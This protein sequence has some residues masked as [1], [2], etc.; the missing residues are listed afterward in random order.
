MSYYSRCSLSLCSNCFRYLESS[1]VYGDSACVN[2]RGIKINNTTRI[3]F[4]NI[5]LLEHHF[6]D[7]KLKNV[8][9]GYELFPKIK[10]QKKPHSGRLG[11]GSGFEPLTFR[12]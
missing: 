11:A 5:V 2:T 9:I 6:L 3:C 10:A 12:L 4:S 8:A 7:V 1:V